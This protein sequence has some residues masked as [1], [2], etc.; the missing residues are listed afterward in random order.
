VLK[1][2]VIIDVFIPGI[3]KEDLLLLLLAARKQG[4]SSVVLWHH[5]QSAMIT[6]KH[7]YNSVN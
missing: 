2:N 6:S 5:I 3:I 4:M 7:R 1:N